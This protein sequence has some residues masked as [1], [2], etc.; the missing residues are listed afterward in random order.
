MTRLK[1]NVANLF[2]INLRAIQYLHIWDKNMHF[3]SS[4]FY[5]KRVRTPDA[6]M[7]SCVHIGMH[8]FF[9]ETISIWFF[10][11]KSQASYEAAQPG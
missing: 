4:L 5:L 7:T 1:C 8:A 11:L 6:Y 9:L 10:P 2:T 3:Y